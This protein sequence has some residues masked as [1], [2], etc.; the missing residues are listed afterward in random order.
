MH[1][2]CFEAQCSIS[3]YRTFKKNFTTK[4]SIITCQT[5]KMFLSVSG[6]FAKLCHKKSCK[7]CVSVLKAQ[8]RGNELPTKVFPLT[9][10][11]QPVR[12]KTMF[13]SVLEHFQKVHHEKSC[14]TFV[15]GLNALFLPTELS[16]NFCYECIQSNLLDLK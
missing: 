7:T 13:G 12:P 5:Q 4:A 16:E 10:P 3:G 1:N 8:F 11:M 9:P 6:F 15:S 2:F 14:K